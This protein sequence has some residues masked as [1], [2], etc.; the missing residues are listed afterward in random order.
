MKEPD[1]YKCKSCAL[2]KIKKDSSTTTRATKKKKPQPT[3]KLHVG[4]HLH[5][6]FGFLRG[7]AFAKKDDTGQT[8][9]SIDGFRS[10]LIVVN[11]ATTSELEFISRANII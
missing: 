10:Y 9:T 7:S 2:Y 8:I 1:S 3:E 11:R 5:M 6:D 4:Q